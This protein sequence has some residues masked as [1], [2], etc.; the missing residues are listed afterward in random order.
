MPFFRNSPGKNR[1]APANF[2]DKALY[3]FVVP[4]AIRHGQ[5][6]GQKSSRKRCHEPFENFS[7]ASRCW[8][9]FIIGYC[10]VAL[11]ATPFLFGIP[12]GIM[13]IGTSL[14]HFRQ[15]LD[16]TDKAERCS[17]WHYV[18]EPNSPTVSFWK[19]RFHQIS[20]EVDD[21]IHMKHLLDHYS[22]QLTRIYIVNIYLVCI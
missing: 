1:F 16:L 9:T 8:S 19:L 14:D 13:S 12:T 5:D 15:V 20:L 6:C 3:I 7:H 17:D 11:K 18:C 2:C 10:E 4:I 21:E 22:I